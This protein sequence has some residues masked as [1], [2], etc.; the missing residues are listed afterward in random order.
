MVSEQA[1]VSF[2]FLVE[3][4]IKSSMLGDDKDACRI[5]KLGVSSQI[6]SKQ[7]VILT[8]SSY[9]FRVMMFVHFTRDKPTKGHFAALKQQSELDDEAF[10]DTVMECGN[11]ACGAVNRELGNFYPHLGMSTPSV[12]DHASMEYVDA[13]G[14]GHV[15]HW[16]V[17]TGSGAVFHVSLAVCEDSPI[18][19][20][21]DQTQVE[22]TSGELEFF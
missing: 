14:A 9:A 7:M 11:L 15:G 20:A 22:D 5:E 8:V 16:R 4:A 3:Q 21:V 13:L 17:A 6:K 19:F 1:K 2:D 18:D 10:L 12:L